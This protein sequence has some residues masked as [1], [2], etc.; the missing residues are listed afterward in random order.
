MPSLQF[1][2]WR[3]ERQP[4]WCGFFQVQ[5]VDEYRNKCREYASFIDETLTLF[6]GELTLYDICHVLSYKMIIELRDARLERLAKEKEEM[7]AESKKMTSNNVRS[8]ILAK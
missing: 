6:K 3:D 1:H 2:I 5:T 4:V 7:E 8:Q